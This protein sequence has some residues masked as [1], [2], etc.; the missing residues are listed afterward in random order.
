MDT[1]EELSQRELLAL[2]EIRLSGRVADHVMLRQLLNDDL[3]A[4]FL[5]SGLEL[6]GKGLGSLVRGSPSLWDVGL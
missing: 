3:I 6:T 4:D 5:G 2:R 1:M